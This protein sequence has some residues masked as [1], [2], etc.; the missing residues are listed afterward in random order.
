[1]GTSWSKDPLGFQHVG[2]RGHF[3]KNP[4]GHRL[5]VTKLRVCD[6]LAKEEQMK[7]VYRTAAKERIRK[8]ERRRRRDYRMRSGGRGPTPNV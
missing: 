2:F 1:M 6:L 4:H 8:M 7:A 3:A 5:I